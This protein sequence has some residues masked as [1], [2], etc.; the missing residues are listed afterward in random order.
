M[1]KLRDLSV[2]QDVDVRAS[3]N[4]SQV[5]CRGAASGTVPDGGLHITHANN[6]ASYGV[7]V[8]RKL[9]KLLGSVVD[10]IVDGEAY[11]REGLGQNTGGTVKSWKAL[12]G[13]VVAVG[14]RYE[15]LMLSAGFSIASRGL[16]SIWGLTR[17]MKGFMLSNDQPLSPV[18][19]ARR[20]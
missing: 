17:V 13:D 6:V 18:I 11:S 12:A 14:G 15:L 5:G 4:T 9:G 1:D 20:S 16:A 8:E 3:D 19:L 2:K 7:N 10:P